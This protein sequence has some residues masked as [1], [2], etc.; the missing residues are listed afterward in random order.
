MLLSSPAQELH[1]EDKDDVQS[2]ISSA[3]DTETRVE[4]DNFHQYFNSTK[5]LSGLKLS[6]F[7]NKDHLPFLFTIGLFKFFR[8]IIILSLT[9]S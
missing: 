5:I 2:D 3:I 8:Y 1:L 7:T 6:Q 4:A 9:Q